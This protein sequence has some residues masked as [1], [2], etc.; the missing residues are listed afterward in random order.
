MAKRYHRDTYVLAMCL[1]K[2]LGTRGAGCSLQC[3]GG[4]GEIGVTVTEVGYG[5]LAVNYAAFD[6]F[7]AVRYAGIGS[8]GA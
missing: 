5:V 4:G 6:S 1:C 7:I 2:I 3:D 8:I